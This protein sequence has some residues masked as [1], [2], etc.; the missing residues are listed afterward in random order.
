M[1][2]VQYDLGTFN[3]AVMLGILSAQAVQAAPTLENKSQKRGYYIA[4][5]NETASA[6]YRSFVND[7]F[8]QYLTKAQT[9]SFTNIMKPKTE[10][11]RRLLEYRRAALAKGMKTLSADEIDAMVKT[12]RGVSA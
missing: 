5:R 11:G 8:T 6:S 4:S 10:L 9:S 1:T 2:K 3:Y 7:P 12:G